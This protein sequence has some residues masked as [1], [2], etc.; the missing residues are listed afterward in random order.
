MSEPTNQFRTAT[1]GGF[2]KQDVQAYLEKSAREHQEQLAQLRAE[3]SEER[4]ARAEDTEAYEGLKSAAEV[5]KEE[6]ERLHAAL[7]QKEAELAQLQAKCEA[8]ENQ[9]TGSQ[10][11]L[12]RLGP[13]AASYEAIK[14]RT[15]SIELEAHGRAQIIEEEARKKAA[16]TRDD[17]LE[18][19]D[20]MQNAYVR[21]RADMDDTV[22]RMVKEIQLS[23]SRI[24]SA[25]DGLTDYDA[26]LNALRAQ[27]A[28][29]EPRMPLPLRTEEPPKEEL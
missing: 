22:A 13:A 11:E 3:L 24:E 10:V 19:V 16:K 7:Q 23:G 1:F 25:A 28:G 8:L 26:A 21:L 5:V 20:K 27:V 15:A 18:W 12:E 9:L 14:N 29:M 2:Q 17:L 6:N 4:S